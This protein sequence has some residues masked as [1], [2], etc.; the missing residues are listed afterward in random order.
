MICAV[1]LD[2]SHD[3]FAN[4][5][6]VSCVARVLDV[7]TIRLHPQD[8]ASIKLWIERLKDENIQIFYKDKLDPSPTGLPMLENDLLLCIQT[9]YQL[10]A[11]QRL[12]HHFIG[13]DATHNTT[14]YKEIM[15]YTMIACDDWGHGVPTFLLDLVPEY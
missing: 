5:G 4:F 6:D 12:S 1:V 11:F 15:L 8:G 14:Q 13:I 7:E 3:K 2:G 10:D 9:P